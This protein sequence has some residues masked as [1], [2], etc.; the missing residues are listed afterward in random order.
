MSVDFPRAWEIANAT[1]A[2]DH[3]PACSYYRST[4]ALLCDCVVL[5]GHPEYTDDVL[6]GRGGVV[7]AAT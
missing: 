7:H 6:H 2:T 1:L 4:G 3:D 5:T